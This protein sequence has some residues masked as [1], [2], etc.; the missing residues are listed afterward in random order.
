MRNHLSEEQFSERAFG[1]AGSEINR[2]LEECPECRR[3]D[4][5][6]RQT[7][8]AFRDSIHTAAEAYERPWRAPEPARRPAW[9][10][11]MAQRWAYA[12]VLAA[13]LVASVILLRIDHRRPSHPAPGVVSEDEIL[14]QV[15][16]DI[17]ENVPKALAP[18]QLLLAGAEEPPAAPAD[19]KTGSKRRN[20][21]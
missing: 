3:Q 13:I 6:L 11:F 1:S 14:M 18:G 4:E 9:A 7:L 8:A 21:R 12:A 19:I 10:G 20:R 15:Q 17:G 16:T 5:E 2:H